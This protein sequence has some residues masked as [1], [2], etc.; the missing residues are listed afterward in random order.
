MLSLFY[1][2]FQM[3]LSDDVLCLFSGILDQRD[4]SSVLEVPERELTLGTLE[5]NT[6]YDVAVIS[7]ETLLTALGNDPSKWSNCRQ[8]PLEESALFCP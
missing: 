6:A 2:R 1:L 4:G 3:D 7:Q 5:S 8:Q